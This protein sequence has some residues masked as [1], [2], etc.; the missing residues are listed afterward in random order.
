MAISNDSDG[1]KAI[2]RIQVMKVSNRGTGFVISLCEA[3]TY[4][5]YFIDYPQYS[6]K[7]IGHHSAQK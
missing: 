3:G 5:L 4:S 6:N 7:P 2:K 1:L